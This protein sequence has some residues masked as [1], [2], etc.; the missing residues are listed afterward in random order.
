VWRPE[1]IHVRREVADLHPPDVAVTG[2]RSGDDQNRAREFFSAELQLRKLDSS[3]RGPGRTSPVTW[4][5][6]AL[7]GICG[8]ESADATFP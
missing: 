7:A 8:D 5:K 6:E 4:Q 1:I 2:R 3:A